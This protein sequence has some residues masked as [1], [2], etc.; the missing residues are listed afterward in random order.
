M[1]NGRSRIVGQATSRKL[2]A[3]TRLEKSGL[4]LKADDT[5]GVVDICTASDIPYGVAPY[6]T[7]K[8]TAN[9]LGT[10]DDSGES[11]MASDYY[12]GSELKDREIPII[13]SGQVKMTVVVSTGNLTVNV[14]SLLVPAAKGYVKPV[15]SNTLSTTAATAYKQI[16]QIVGKSEESWTGTDGQTKEILVTLG[17]FGAGAP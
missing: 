9:Y 7:R 16:T 6:S 8:E 11:D 14:G 3:A 1:S 4:L 13:R 2:K 15:V 17:M 10:Y 12:L 5:T